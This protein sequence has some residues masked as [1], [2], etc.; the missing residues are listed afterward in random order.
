MQGEHGEKREGTGGQFGDEQAPVS[1]PSPTAGAA[2]EQSVAADEQ[3]VTPDAQTATADAQTV[4]TDAQPSASDERPFVGK[5]AFYTRKRALLIAFALIAAL[6]STFIYVRNRRELSSALKAGADK[7]KEVLTGEP[8]PPRDPYAEAVKLVEA[9]RGEATGRAA[10]AEIPVELKQYKEPRR[11]LAIQSAAAAEAGIRPPHDFAELA[12]MIREGRDYVEAP[13]LGR[14]YVLYG[15][16]LTAT[17]EL[18][19][20]DVRARKVVPLFADAEELKAYVD[21]LAADRERIT[22]EL[23]DL[24]AQ[25]KQVARGDRA[26]RTRLLSE[27]ATR[28]KEL[29]RLKESGELVAAY[30]GK[31]A[32]QTPTTPGK[33]ADAGAKAADAGAKSADAGKPAAGAKPSGGAKTAAGKK[34]AGGAKTADKGKGADGKKTTGVQGA[35]G[36]AGK[37]AKESTKQTA[38]DKPSAAPEPKGAARLFEEYALLADLARDFGGRSYD[39]HDKESAREF[40]ARLLSFLR[41]PALAVLEELGTAYQAKFERPLPATSLVRT[42]EY[43]RLLRE[44]GNPNAADVQP[45]P[46]TTGLAFD[47]YYRFM[48]AAEQEFVMGEIARLEREGRVE[49]LREL[50]D[51]YHVFVF[52]EG[53]PPDAK[54]VDKILGKPS[55]KK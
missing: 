38:A 37:G 43:Q 15:V 51:H 54:R 25:L 31:A 42:E 20:Y 21:G 2:D 52:P 41:P 26:E 53:H 16:G 30:Y 32:A 8:S 22:S 4:K 7:A 17:G 55:A 36:S 47:I 3:S 1:E 12:G 13:R 44:S 9:D 19:H 23:K 27:T 49:A 48:T 35:K 24:D 46:H 6:T 45:P 33:S 5:K 10:Q 50:R 11:F 14:G 39:L 18:T 29:T 34:N 28:R 40:Q